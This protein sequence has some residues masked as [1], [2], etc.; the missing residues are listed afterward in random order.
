MVKKYL[1]WPIR[2]FLYL[3]AIFILAFYSF[4]LVIST[5]YGSQLITNYLFKD[6]FKYQEISIEPNLLGMQVDI[7]NFQYIG[8]ADFS[9]EEIKLQIDFLNSIVGNKI[10][11][12]EFSLKNAEVKL[13]ENERSKQIDQTEVFINVLSIINLKVGNTVFQELRLSNFLTYKD[14]FGFNFENLNLDLQGNLK[15]LKG[16]DGKGYFSD[17][18]LFGDLITREGALYFSF[19]ED[20]QILENLEGQIYLDFNNEFKI[21]YANISAFSNETNLKL[22]FK[23]DEEFQLQM[24]S[25]GDGETLLSYLPKSQ[26]DLKNFFQDSNFKAEQL[27]ILFSISSF[28][29]KLNFSSV[30]VSNGNLINVGGAEL[31][32]NNL[33]TYIDNSSI[34]LFGDDFLISDY[35]LGNMYLVNNFTYE[36]KYELLLDDR[37]TSL[38]FDNNGRFLSIYGDFFPTESLDISVNFNDKDL[39][40]N[41]KDIFFEFNYLD[42][43]AFQNN[44][45]TIFP[46]N[47]KSNFFSINEKELNSFDF[48]LS[49]FS[50]K[51][52]NSKLSIKSQDENPL[53]N[54]N[55]RF[56]KLNLGLNNSYVN[57]E[58]ENLE[59]GGLIDISGEN[60]SYSDTTFTID[61]LRVLSLIDIRSR[62]LNIL[63]A[64]FEKLDQNNFFINTLDGKVFI[65]S[66]GYANIDQL[67]MNFDVGNAE[68]SGTISSDKES[69]DDFNLE[70]TFNSTLSES[71]PWYVAILGGL[72]AAASAVVV[73]EVLED[74]LI[75]ITSSKYSIS[76][77][78]DNLDIEFMQ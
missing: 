48:D 33:K 17:G 50:F 21:P 35:S 25:R 70:M 28:K 37:R 10:Y 36:D 2:L 39:V 72:P 27:D 68:L 24:F 44:I 62:L 69:F 16:L 42:S 12:S 56:G 65:D 14:T 47:F 55:L 53:R 78:V 6:N 18:K 74:G 63:N 5:N 52:I 58:D 66:S 7:E 8:A 59:F 77:N 38:K 71:I 75:D 57:I 23:Y 40:F 34:N 4:C 32:V 11:V 22:K 9:G 67:K 46:K 45:L 41:Y 1:I 13:S 31:K 20:P 3:I 43:Y 73:T 76:G 49:N 29:D 54:S 51:N 15:A 60:I 26:R 19:F 61:A 64:D 30:I